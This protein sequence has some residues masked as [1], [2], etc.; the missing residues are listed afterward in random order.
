MMYGEPEDQEGQC[1]ARLFIAD[2][3]GDGHA[4]MRCQLNP[5]HT[6]PHQEVYNA[7]SEEFPNRVTVIWERDETM[8]CE[9]H[10][11]QEIDEPDPDYPDCPACS[12]CA[13]EYWE[14]KAEEENAGG[15]ED[16]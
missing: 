16:S 9:K 7:G 8:I 1:N 10:G 4:T 14:K 13:S 15:C 12:E 11:R 5:D 3:H 6:G 2:I